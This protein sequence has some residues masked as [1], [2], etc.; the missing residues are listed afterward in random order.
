TRK[1]FLGGAAG[2]AL[3]AAGIYELVD[4]LTPSP[5]RPRVARPALPEQHLL[6]GVRTVVDNDVEVLVPPLHH[7]IVTAK[8]RIGRGD[9]A[10]LGD[11]RGELEDV[12]RQLDSRYAPS[13]AALGVTVAWGLPY[14]AHF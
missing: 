13:P 2:A 10:A 8:V 9:R 7:Q 5:K 6:E 1:D 12:L 4:R 11:A 3:A 14:F